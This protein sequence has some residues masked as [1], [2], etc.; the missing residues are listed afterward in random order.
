MIDRRKFITLLGSGTLGMLLNGCGGGGGGSS[1]ETSTGTGGTGAVSPTVPASGVSGR[2][3]VVGGGMAGATVAE[4]LRLGGGSGLDVPL[5]ERDRQY[6]SNILSNLVLTGQRSMAS[7][8]Y[9]HDKLSS[10]YGVKVVY[11]NVA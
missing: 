4:C 2:V 8:A 11:G 6:Q 9:T 7:L 5:I 3:V 10:A 1:S